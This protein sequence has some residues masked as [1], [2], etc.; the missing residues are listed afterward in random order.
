MEGVA[1][2]TGMINFLPPLKTEKQWEGETM[3]KALGLTPA[4][5]E[6]QVDYLNS[7]G[8]R[9]LLDARFFTTKYA[10]MRIDH[11]LTTLRH[12]RSLPGGM[13]IEMR[14]QIPPCDTDPAL[15]AVRAAHGEPDLTLTDGERR[16]F[17]EKLESPG[18]IH[19]YDRFGFIVG[20]RKGQTRIPAR[21]YAGI[22]CI[23]SEARAGWSDVE[24]RAVAGNRS[25]HLLSRQKGDRAD[26]LLG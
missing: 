19:Y 17:D 23:R 4:P 1:T 9:I 3:E 18:A 11:L 25:A 16:V 15:D 24:R 10:A 22:G 26:R 12:S 7:R 5:V 8:G 2:L 13:F 20:E 21:R 14:I 6:K